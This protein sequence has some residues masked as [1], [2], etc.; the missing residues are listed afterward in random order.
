MSLVV[1]GADPGATALT[2]PSGRVV[3]VACAA[4]L[5]FGVLLPISPVAAVVAVGLWPLVF[6]YPVAGL[7]VLLA[8]TVLVPVD[9]Q[10]SLSVIGGR[11]RP[12]LLVVDVLML[13]SLARIVWLL[14]T[15]RLPLDR[16][17]LAGLA[18]GAIV[19]LSTLWGLV[20]GADTSETGHE[21]RRVILGVAA[22]VLALP[23]VDDRRARRHLQWA[24]VGIGGALAAWG[25]AQ[26]VFAV[27][28]TPAGDVGIRPGVALT[29]SGHGQLQGGMY[30]FGIAVILIWAVLLSGS[31]TARW[32]QGAL[33]VMLLANA[34]CLVLTFERSLWIA[35]VVACAA[36]AVVSGPEARGRA[37]RLSAV[38]C[39]GLLVVAAFVPGVAR[40]AVER[41]ASVGQVSTDSSFE[42]R[43]VESRAVVERIVER[44]VTGSGF[45]NTITWGK[46]DTFATTTTPFSHNGYLWLI[47]KIG[48]P[49][50]ALV[51]GLLTVIVVRRTP[52]GDDAQWAALQR[53][54]RGAL[55]SLLAICMLF[56][57]VNALGITAA[58]GVVAALGCA[59]VHEE[60]APA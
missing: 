31:V 46:R 47:W 5:A 19:V 49:A 22:F 2:P 7:S 8:V 12:G 36:V 39:A 16:R 4:A 9:V 38:G 15:A 54:G 26:W 3:A 30:A 53:G 6:V 57:V 24:L 20:L 48:V 28:Y 50:S 58:L 1:A 42:A 55:L 34:A 17:M 14:A 21:A 41:L 11:D 60:G 40:T 43:V 56:P 13:V 44:P 18:V 59:R 51:F 29:S 25:L 27:G 23:V 33:A 45:G 10:D 35:T 52:P 32:Q 37:L